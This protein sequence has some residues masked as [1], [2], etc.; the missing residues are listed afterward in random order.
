[1]FFPTIFRFFGPTK[2]FQTFH[3]HFSQ[4][5]NSVTEFPT[6]KPSPTPLSSGSLWQ[7]VLLQV[8]HALGESWRGRITSTQKGMKTC[9]YTPETNMTKETTTI[10]P[11]EDVS[12]LLLKN[13][14]FS[15]VMLV[16]RRDIRWGNLRQTVQI[17]KKNPLPSK[18]TYSC[19]QKKDSVK[20]QEKR[21]T[22]HWPMAAMAG[23]HFSLADSLGS[24][25][26]GF[27]PC[28]PLGVV[29]CW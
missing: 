7:P 29:F 27:S 3:L 26:P 20:K 28:D 9:T 19:E 24:S 5:C 13:L 8:N 18:K 14:W 22:Y 25:L 11:F 4:R 21:Y 17:W 12:R 15:I 2:N 1:M 16:F 10:L 6:K 23:N